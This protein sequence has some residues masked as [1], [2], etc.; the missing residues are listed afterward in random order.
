MA[1]LLPRDTGEHGHQ[2]MNSFY[3]PCLY[4][5][6]KL[7][8]PVAQGANISCIIGDDEGAVSK[9]MAADTNSNLLSRRSRRA[10]K[11]EGLSAEED[12]I[13]VRSVCPLERRAHFIAWMPVARRY[14]VLV[15]AMECDVV[16]R[17][18]CSR[19]KVRCINDQVFNLR[20]TIAHY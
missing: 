4:P 19:R 14:A 15:R 5:A 8:D 6:P 9:T 10:L 13:L 16:R 11:L 3:L 7:A 17:R 12:Y 18:L 20:P 1:S 2:N